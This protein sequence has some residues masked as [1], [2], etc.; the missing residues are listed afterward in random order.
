ME[1]RKILKK[2]RGYWLKNRVP[3]ITDTNVKFYV[4]W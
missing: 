2:L 4:I 1:R 3:N